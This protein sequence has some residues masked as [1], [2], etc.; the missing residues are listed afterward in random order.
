MA[1]KK[2][3]SGGLTF[4]RDLAVCTDGKTVADFEKEGA[5]KAGMSVEEWRRAVVNELNAAT[6]DSVNAAFKSGEGTTWSGQGQAMAG[7]FHDVAAGLE[8]DGGYQSSDKLFDLL[9]GRLPGLERVGKD[10]VGYNEYKRPMWTYLKKKGLVEDRNWQHTSAVSWVGPDKKRMYATN[11]TP[12]VVRRSGT[13]YDFKKGAI[14]KLV[15]QKDPS[16]FAYAQVLGVGPSGEGKLEISQGAW[17]YLGYPSTGKSTPAGVQGIGYATVVSSGTSANPNSMLTG[18]QIQLAGSLGESGLLTQ[19]KPGGAVTVD[20]LKSSVS[21]LD[22]KKQQTL[23][24][25]LNAGARRELERM[26]KP[27][28]EKKADASG[29]PKLLRGFETVY[30]GTTMRRVGYAA[31]R[32]VHEGGGYVC[33]GSDSV[34]V[35][36]SPLARLYD[37]T[38]D[39][40]AVE[41][42]LE[43][44]VVGGGT[45]SALV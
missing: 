20:D 22:A 38:S 13:A 26:Q 27:A 10:K 14:V 18:D 17:G 28:E 45:T 33:E 12:Y 36:N 32:C 35:G 8:A 7:R 19:A 25:N 9:E 37:G 30:A 21:A 41:T 29:G 16:N 44:V 39:G 31:A 11:M 43:T 40:Q 34:F 15:D 6:K 24:K 3:K 5:A 23:E 2:K 1:K 4:T 42:G